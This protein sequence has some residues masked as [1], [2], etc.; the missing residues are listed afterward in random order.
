MRILIKIICLFSIS[1][2]RSHF[3]KTFLRFK[4]VFWTSS[5]TNNLFYFIVLK[6][7]DFVILKLLMFCIT[8][9]VRS[10]LFLCYC[11]CISSNDLQ[12]RVLLLLWLVVLVRVNLLLL[13]RLLNRNILITSL[14]CVVILWNILSNNIHALDLFNG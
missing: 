10:F 8:L 1:Q 14:H 4:L 9:R 11:L 12:S 13:F 5:F 6:L 3:P 7:R 2:Q